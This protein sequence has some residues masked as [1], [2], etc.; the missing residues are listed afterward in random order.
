M[1]SRRSC[2]GIGV[3]TD[4]RWGP[5]RNQFFWVMLLAHIGVCP[6]ATAP[7][8][9]LLTFLINQ[10]EAAW[11][12]IHSLQTI[13]YTHETQWLANGQQEPFQGVAQI[14]KKGDWYWST[15]RRTIL[16]RPTGHMQNN[17]FRNVMNDKYMAEWPMLGNPLAY[18][19]DHAS[20]DSMSRKQR[21][22]FRLTSP[23]DFLPACFGSASYRFREDMARGGDGVKFEA[24]EV[25]GEDGR[26][27]YQITRS[28]PQTSATPDLMWVIDPQKGFLAVESTFYPSGRLLM[29]QTMGVE[30]IAPGLWYPV[31]YEETRYKE[32]IAPPVVESWVKSRIKDIKINEPLPDEQFAFDALG[33][34]RDKPDIRVLRTGLD[35]VTT[36]YVYRGGQL[37]PRLLADQ[38]DRVVEKGV[39]VTA[40]SI[41]Q[42][43]GPAAQSGARPGQAQARTDRVPA[44]AGTVPS[45]NRHRLAI[46]FLASV[47]AIVIVGAVLVYRHP[48]S[49]K[50][51]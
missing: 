37:V 12:K 45:N 19:W 39:E 44:M 27:L 23:Y 43:G 50:T 21:T 11:Q 8:G 20:I 16:D 9:D 4:L 5:L 28:H 40:D 24:V 33:L 34:K 38:V 10:N 13:Q 26:L 6:G 42:E 35:G 30:E 41:T 48:Q 3:R 22:H 7:Q 36:E 47:L 2:I 31:G 15:Y 46:V 49:D 51:R 17:E 1:F 25:K 14:K 18:Q 29:R 32:G